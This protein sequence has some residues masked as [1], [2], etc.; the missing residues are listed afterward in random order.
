MNEGAEICVLCQF[1][2]QECTFIQSPQPR[3]RRLASTSAQGS[4]EQVVKKRYV[5]SYLIII[6]V[7]IGEGGKKLLRIQLPSP[8]PEFHVF[9]LSPANL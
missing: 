1:H 7:Q 2:S 5:S 3:K 6:S 9:L 8:Y 4:E